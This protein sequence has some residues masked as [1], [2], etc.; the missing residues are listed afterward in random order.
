MWIIINLNDV[1]KKCYIINGDKK[2]YIIT[3]SRMNKIYPKI[4]WDQ[5]KW[6]SN[7][8]KSDAYWS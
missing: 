2:C 1:R 4:V 5:Y 3:I 6:V 8:E 7:W